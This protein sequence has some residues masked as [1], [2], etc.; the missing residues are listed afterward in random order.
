MDEEA[1]A[2]LQRDRDKVLAEFRAS[3]Q[4]WEE[5]NSIHK[6]QKAQMSAMLRAAQL[7]SDVLVHALRWKH[8]DSHQLVSQLVS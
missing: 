8:S 6:Q 4:S 1:F 3:H 2:E 5:I 7:R